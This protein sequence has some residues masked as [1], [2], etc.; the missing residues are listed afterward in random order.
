MVGARLKALIRRTRLKQ[1]DL[2]RDLDIEESALSRMLNGKQV[3]PFEVVHHITRAAG[4]TVSELLAEPGY[5]LPHELVDA[6]ETVVAEAR[7]LPI[8]LP[9]PRL[10][11]LEARPTPADA[12][13]APL[14]FIG[15]PQVALVADAPQ[16]SLR[17]ADI[18]PRLAAAGANAVIEVMGTQ[19]RESGILPGDQ[20]FV[21][22]TRS[23]H[24]ADREVV[25]CEIDG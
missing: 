24:E 23:L 1:S 17:V 3:L 7:R 15:M 5:V 10:R 18:P 4:I 12:A 11:R 16:P 8:A 6:L 13:R 9:M 2:A 14:T 20:L 19:W 22:L 25:V 21:R